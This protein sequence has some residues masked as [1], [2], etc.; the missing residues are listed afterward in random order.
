[1]KKPN[2]FSAF[3]TPAVALTSVGIMV[4]SLLVQLPTYS[5][6]FPTTG[7]TGAPERTASGGRRDDSCIE[8]GT[9]TAVKVL[10]PNNSLGNT[11]D[12]LSKVLLQIPRTKAKT[13][14]FVVMDEA[15]NELFEKAVALPGTT[16]VMQLDIPPHVTLKTHKNYRWEFSI[17][18]DAQ[19]RTKDGFVRGTIQ[20]PQLSSNQETQ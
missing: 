5:L 18:C 8:A 17:V 3:K 19:D 4:S 7:G 14:E 1:M 20:P 9:L 6:D 12:R 16:D 13:A 15:G 2:C 10:V 11:G